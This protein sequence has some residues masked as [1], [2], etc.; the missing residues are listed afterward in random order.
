MRLG[1]G[2]GSGYSMLRV[3]VG[4]GLGHLAGERLMHSAAAAALQGLLWV[5]RGAPRARMWP[6]FHTSRPALAA[7]SQRCTKFE[8]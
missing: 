3:H 4:Y 5:G 1:I 7:P 8:T 2:L 6:Y